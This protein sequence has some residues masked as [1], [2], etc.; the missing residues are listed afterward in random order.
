MEKRFVCTYW[1]EKRWTCLYNKKEAMEFLNSVGAVKQN[2][3][4]RDSV[5][6]YREWSSHDWTNYQQL[7]ALVLASGNGGLNLPTGK[8]ACGENARGINPFCKQWSCEGSAEYEEAKTNN[9]S[10]LTI[11]RNQRH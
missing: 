6:P 11:I 8:I 1:D 9:P 2:Q 10:A 3:P 5:D 7:M 4:P